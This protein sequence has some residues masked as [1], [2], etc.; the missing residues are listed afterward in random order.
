MDY[1][2][3]K[4]WWIPYGVWIILSHSEA[5]TATNPAIEGPILAKIT[6]LGP[7]GA[8]AAAAVKLQSQ[9]IRDK[10]Q[11][12]GGKGVEL[13]FVWAVGMILDIKRRGKGSSPC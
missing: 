5:C 4:K 13:L 6:A 1:K 11:N 10:N 3:A 8:V 2:I 12:S 9:V 7:W